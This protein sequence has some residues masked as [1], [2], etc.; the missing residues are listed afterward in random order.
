MARTRLLWLT[1][2]T[3][4]SRFRP[5]G[6]RVAQPARA[7]AAARMREVAAWSAGQEQEQGGQLVELRGGQFLPLGDGVGG[8]PFIA[9]GEDRATHSR[10]SPLRLASSVAYMAALR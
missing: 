5:A 4:V 3:E 2:F 10:V 6:P 9:G 1:A 7:A 8:H